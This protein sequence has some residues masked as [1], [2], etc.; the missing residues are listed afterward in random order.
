MKIKNEHF[1]IL[2]SAIQTHLDN[3]DLDKAI[4]HIEQIKGDPRVFNT[5]TRFLF[6]L[7]YASKLRIGSS[8][9]SGLPLYDYMDDTHILT[10][11]RRAVK[12][13][14]PSLLEACK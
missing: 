2:E 9:T 7:L 12:N 5:E 10:A 4:C 6:D 13:Y 1:E 11:L 8:D 3:L 14:N